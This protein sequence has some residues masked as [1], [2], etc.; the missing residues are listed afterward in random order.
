MDSFNIAIENDHGNSGF[1]NWKWWFSIVFCMFTRGYLNIIATHR[2]LAS[3]S[4]L[5]KHRCCNTTCRGVFYPHEVPQWLP[6]IASTNNI[7]PLIVWYYMILYNIISDFVILCIQLYAIV[8]MDGCMHACMYVCI[9]ICFYQQEWLPTRPCWDKTTSS[10][11][12]PAW[13]WVGSQP[14]PLPHSPSGPESKRRHGKP[15]EIGR[16][17]FFSFC[18]K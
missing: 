13:S 15:C 8:W 18:N 17:V 6:A 2:S 5:H 11:S 12:S 4:H 1:L 9:Y 7:W 3:Q 16:S 10:P 14:S